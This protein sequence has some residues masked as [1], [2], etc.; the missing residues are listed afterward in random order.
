MDAAQLSM[1]AKDAARHTGSKR[2]GEPPTFEVV[3]KKIQRPRTRRDEERQHYRF[4]GRPRR[5][6]KR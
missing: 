2:M 6:E 3:K 4:D 5:N 1:Q